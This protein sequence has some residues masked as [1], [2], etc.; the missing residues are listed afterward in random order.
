MK[1][2]LCH[3]NQGADQLL[4]RLLDQYPGLDAKLKKGGSRLAPPDYLAPVI[5]IGYVAL[6]NRPS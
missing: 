4:Q 2:R 5:S 1:I 6:G 3:H